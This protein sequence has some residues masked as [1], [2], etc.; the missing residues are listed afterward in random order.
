MIHDGISCCLS[1]NNNDKIRVY[2]GGIAMKREAY[3]N[4]LKKIDHKQE[5]KKAQ[6]HFSARKFTTKLLKYAKKMGV[7]LSYY[8]MLLFYS[9]QSPHTS[10][11]DK[12]VIAGAL[13]YLIVPVDLIPDFIP[14]IGFADDLSIIVYAVSRVISN[15]DRDMKI[16]ANQKIKQ[17]FGEYYDDKDIEADVKD[18]Q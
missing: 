5:I 10:K 4:K 3:E 2:I 11:K 18:D 12:L 8:S 1:S 17:L 9:Y 14:V 16:R 7:K 6:K 13:G 15:I